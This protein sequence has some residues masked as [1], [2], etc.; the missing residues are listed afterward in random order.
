MKSLV[1]IVAICV[2]LMLTPVVLAAETGPATGWIRVSTFGATA[3]G[4]SPALRG[5]SWRKKLA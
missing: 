2:L 5:T 3:G 4:G 1:S